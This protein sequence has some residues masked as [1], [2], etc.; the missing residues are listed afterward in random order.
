[1]F[2]EKKDTMRYLALTHDDRHS[3]LNTIGVDTIDALYDNVP[4]HLLTEGTIPGIPDHKGELEVERELSAIA[5]KNIS[6]TQS[7]FFLGAGCYYHHVPSTVD[8]IIQRS[9]FLTSYTP[10]QPEISQGTLV[11]IFEFQTMIAQLT[12]QDI[13]NASMYDGS[14]A[15]AEAALMAMRLTKKHNI[16]IHGEFHPEYR[17]VLDT[18]M[19]TRDHVAISHDLPDENTACMI[20]QYPDFHGNIPDLDALRK[21]CDDTGA[22]LV[23][24]VTEIVSLG[25]LPAPTVADIVVGEAQSLGNPMSFGGPHLGF[26]ACKNQYVRQIPGRLVGETVDE[27]GKRGFVL[28]LNTREQHIRREKATSNICSNQGLCALAFTVHLSLLGEIGFTQ[29]ATLNHERACDLADALDAIDGVSVVN[30]HFFNEFVISLPVD[31]SKVVKALAQQHIVAGLALEDNKLLVAATEMTTEDAIERFA[32]S[33]TNIVKD[34]K[35]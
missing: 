30:T 10:Y 35:E 33:L 4:S 15:A 25:L 32:T 28:T 29:L 24:V 5:K 8:Y 14:T 20:V 22:M 26:F 17:E 1:M 34:I 12:G 3:M 31:S 13:A 6:A 19:K 27:D 18:F 23:V 9:E 7:D 2:T 11:A 21:A 16:S